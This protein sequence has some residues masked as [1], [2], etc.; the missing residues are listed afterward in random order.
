MW[1]PHGWPDLSTEKL[2]CVVEAERPCGL[3]CHERLTSFFSSVESAPVA[4]HGPTTHTLHKP[5][6][7]CE[8]VRRRV[9]RHLTKTGV[10]A[11]PC[12]TPITFAPFCKKCPLRSMSFQ[13]VEVNTG[14]GMDLTTLQN[15]GS[16]WMTRSRMPKQM[17]FFLAFPETMRNTEG[18]ELLPLHWRFFLY[19]LLGF[20][21]EVCFTAGWEFV[22][23][24]NFKFPGNTS[25]WSFVIYGTSLLICERVRQYLL[26]RD[27]PLLARAFVYTVWAFTWEFCW[28]MILTSLGW[29]A[30]DYTPFDYDVMG[31]ITLEYTPAWYVGSIFTDL[32]IIP[33]TMSLCWKPKGEKATSEPIVNGCVKPKSGWTHL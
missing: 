27:V 20:A 22:V 16:E 3:L 25:L 21:T 26:D 17:K 12:S 4:G 19:G 30:W 29:N 7:Y 32:F 14:Y 2:A 31:I 28:G 33:Y 6:W 24:L 9:R 15:H 18:P 11:K 8:E 13:M 23:N 1:A 10:E 5:V